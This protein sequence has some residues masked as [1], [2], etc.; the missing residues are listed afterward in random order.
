MGLN[1][2]FNHR[3]LTFKP[4]HRP[5]IMT[6]AFLPK[7]KLPTQ[8]G[9]SYTMFKR[10]TST[11]ITGQ[12]ASKKSTAQYRV[13]YTKIR[14][15]TKSYDIFTGMWELKIAVYAMAQM[16]SHATTVIHVLPH[17]LYAHREKK[18]KTEHTATNL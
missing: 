8:I 4:K 6:L 3:L 9:Y 7:I 10:S 11:I 15:L 1:C 2:F 5:E 18:I 14:S 13:Q 16:Q 12:Q 17:I